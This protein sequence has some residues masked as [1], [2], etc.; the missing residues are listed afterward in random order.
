MGEIGQRTYA[1]IGL[2]RQGGVMI[3]DVSTPRA[4]LFV[5]YINNRDFSVD[6]ATA[7]AAKDLGPEGI[8][9]IDDK[10][11]PTREPLLV[12]ANEI[13]GTVTIYAVTEKDRD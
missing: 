13:S 4:P 11:S 5:D 12:V 8:I 10:D 3:Y 2:E 9:F 1:F 7:S 6:P